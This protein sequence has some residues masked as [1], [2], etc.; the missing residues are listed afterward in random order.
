MSRRR[1]RVNSSRPNGQA[2]PSSHVRSPS[3]PRLSGAEAE[4]PVTTPDSATLGSA[5]SAS[6]GQSGGRD[7][8]SLTARGA[9]DASGAG[10]RE[11]RF[12]AAKKAEAAMRLLRGESLDVLSRELAVTAATLSEWRDAFLA[13]G[14]AALKSRQ[15]TPQDDEILHLKAMIGDLAMRNELLLERAKLAEAASPFPWRRSRG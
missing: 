2:S 14:E 3:A 7:A 5:E 8:R 4:R 13:G 11:R 12:S 15:V 9:T 10:P 1:H 6:A